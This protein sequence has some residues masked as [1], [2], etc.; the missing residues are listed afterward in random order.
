MAIS[1]LPSHFLHH[2]HQRQLLKIIS[3]IANFDLQ[4]VSKVVRSA[5]GGGADY[6]DIACSAELVKLAKSLTPLPICVSAVEPAQFIPAVQAGADLLEIGNYD[7][8]YAQGRQFTPAE[9]LDMTQ[10]TRQLFPEICLTVTVPHY[11]P[12]N[13]QAQLAE[14]LQQAGAD[15]IQTEGGTSSQPQHSGI[16]GLLE[17][18]IPTLSAAYTISRAVALPVICASGLSSV[19]APL[20]IAVGAV[21]VGVGSAVNRLATEL[22]MVAVVKSLRQALSPQPQA[23]L[24]D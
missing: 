8:F 17:K 21:G 9:I 2:L 19:T 4:L 18:A 6:I 13:Q 1:Y 16:Q 5:D 14:Q 3:G 20:A 10:Q 22:E 12:L 24:K 15:M 7:A 11:L 23:A